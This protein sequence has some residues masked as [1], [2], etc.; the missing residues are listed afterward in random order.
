[1]AAMRFLQGLYFFLL[2]PLA[3]AL[4]CSEVS[5]SRALADDVSNDVIVRSPALVPTVVKVAKDYS[6]SKLSPALEKLVAGER[7]ALIPDLAAP[8]SGEEIL[9]LLS[10]QRK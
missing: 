4:I 1:M 8:F 9:L 2:I 7:G 10:I 3:L 5:E 6:I